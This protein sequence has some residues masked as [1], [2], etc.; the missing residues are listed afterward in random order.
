MSETAKSIQLPAAVV[1]R[2]NRAAKKVN[3]D[4]SDLAVEALEWYLRVCSLPDEMPSRSELRAIRRGREAFKK[5]DYITLDEFRREEALVRRPR[6][7]R[8]KIS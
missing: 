1:R 4:P 3:R 6:R 8:A 7:A 5:G 2:V